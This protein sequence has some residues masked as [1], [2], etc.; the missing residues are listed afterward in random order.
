MFHSER[1]T[2]HELIEI[3]KQYD[4]D[5]KVQFSCYYSDRRPKFEI[6]DDWDDDGIDEVKLLYIDICNCR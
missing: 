2:V 1:M 5:M 4:G 6:I 3:L